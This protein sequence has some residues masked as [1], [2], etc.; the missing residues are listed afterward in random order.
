MHGVMVERS[1]LE[2]LLPELR[3]YATAICGVR[4]DAEDL[5]QDA[6]ERTLRSKYRPDRL[7]EL[8]PWMFRVIRNLHYDELRKKRVRREY[9]AGE[10]RLSD[11][12]GPL[13]GPQDALLRLAFGKLAQDA[14]EVLCLVDVMGFKYAEAAEILDVPVGTIMSRVSRARKALLLLVD[15]PGERDEEESERK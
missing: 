14:R 12:T 11:E 4:H 2:R 3:A 7:A 10:A 5:V 1:H 6:V 13:P 9:S 15:G 8:R